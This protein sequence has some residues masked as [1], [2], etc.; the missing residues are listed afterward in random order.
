MRAN[1]EQIGAAETLT[2]GEY[3]EVLALWARAGLPARPEGR[4]A[5]SAFAKQY[6]GGL[7]RAIGIR[8]DGLLVA[9][10]LLTH[11]GRKGWINRLAVDP[12]FRRKGYA[13]A[14]IEEAERWF[15]DEVGVEVSSALIHSHNDASRA[16]F[17]E[18]G[19]ETID[20]VYVRKLARPGA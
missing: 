17:A 4:D 5:P 11:D 9:V 19:Y 18:L 16:L 2:P 13:A 20:V 12:D 14:L 3:E 7:Q 1:S 15:K 8:A 10:A 6:A